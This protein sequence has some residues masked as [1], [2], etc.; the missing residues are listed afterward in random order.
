MSFFGSN[1]FPAPYTKREYLNRY[2]EEQQTRVNTKAP[3]TPIDH[4]RPQDVSPRQAQ[5]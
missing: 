5:Q 3:P 1:N 4:Y 2:N